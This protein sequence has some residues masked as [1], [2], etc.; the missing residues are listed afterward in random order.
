MTT[1]SAPKLRRILPAWEALPSRQEWVLL[2]LL[3]IVFFLAWR[4]NPDFLAPA[5]QIEL[6]THIWELALL[7]IPMTLIILTA[8]IDLSVGSTMALCAVVFALCFNAHLPVAVC[9]LLSLLTGAAAGAL[10]GVFVASVKVHPLIVTLATLAAY[11]GI[12]E[13]LSRGQAVS[14]FPAGFDNLGQGTLAGL[15]IPGL[16]FIVLLLVTGFVLAR[17][18][19]GVWLSAIGY[20]ETASRFS[21]IATARIKF[22]LYTASGLAAALASLLFV[23]RHDT[24]KADIGQ[25][26]ELGVITA[27]VL[28]GTSIFGGRG[29]LLGTVLGVLLIHETRE[30][31]SWQWEKD[32]LNLIVIGLLLV[33]SVLADGLLSAKK[34]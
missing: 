15:P 19:L 28:G 31:V 1:P 3:G 12:A 8:G 17:T 7:A 26:M 21:G 9:V 30:F 4:L 23:A 29:R 5:A 10:N 2:G 14:H 24:A 13:G 11:R 32:E 27:V 33:L 6:S 34:R 16:I 22:W 20:N 25:G 18:P